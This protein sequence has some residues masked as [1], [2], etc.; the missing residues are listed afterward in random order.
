MG[1]VAQ[2]KMSKDLETIED[3]SKIVCKTLDGNS[4]LRAE[5]SGIMNDLDGKIQKRK[6]DLIPQIREHE[7]LYRMTSELENTRNALVKD[8]NELL[9]SAGIDENT[10]FEEEAKGLLYPNEEN[11]EILK[12]Y[13]IRLIQR[14]LLLRVAERRRLF[15]D[16]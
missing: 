4:I 3:L 1:D 16:V 15:P 6:M 12:G 14:R 8:I 7:E 2:R 9:K 11:I 13:V 5:L 10:I